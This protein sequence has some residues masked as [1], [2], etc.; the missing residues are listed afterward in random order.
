[1]AEENEEVAAA[2]AAAAPAKE[3]EKAAEPAPAAKASSSTVKASDNPEVWKAVAMADHFEKI[4]K[5]T[6]DKLDGVPNFRRVPG[7]KVYCCGQPTKE[8]FDKVIERVCGDKYPKNQKDKPIIW[9]NMRQ[10]PI[11]YVNGEPVCARPANKI[12]EYAELGNVT[13]TWS[14]HSIIFTS[15]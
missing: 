1:M 15:S 8:G 5:L 4:Q 11:I 14:E 7:Y 6:D 3:E 13:S 2:A 12:G 9:I 10:E